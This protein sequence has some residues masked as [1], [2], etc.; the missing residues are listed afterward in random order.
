MGGRDVRALG[1]EVGRTGVRARTAS[2]QPVLEAGL[3]QTDAN[4]LFF[5]GGEKML[6]TFADTYTVKRRGKQY[7]P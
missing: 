7:L 1:E 3:D 4:Q 2:A 6:V 5:R